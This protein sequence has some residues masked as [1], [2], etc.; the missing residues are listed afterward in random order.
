MRDKPE[1]KQDDV[2][3]WYVEGNVAYVKGDV[4]DVFGNVRGSVRGNVRGSV[5]VLSRKCFLINLNHGPILTS[6]LLERS[7][8][9]SS[10]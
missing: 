7:N 6:P 3:D 2:G 9:S 1:L 8:S 5:L 4:V 10:F